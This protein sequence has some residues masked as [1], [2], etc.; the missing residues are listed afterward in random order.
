MSWNVTIVEWIKST[1]DHS[2]KWYVVFVIWELH[3]CWRVWYYLSNNA[4]WNWRNELT[5]VCMY[6]CKFDFCTPHNHVHAIKWPNFGLSRNGT[7]LVIIDSYLKILNGNGSVVTD[8]GEVKPPFLPTHKC[9]GV[10][11]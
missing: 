5:Y 3:L 10:T 11:Y 8:G 7:L 9:K 6:V 4:D 1:D 2:G